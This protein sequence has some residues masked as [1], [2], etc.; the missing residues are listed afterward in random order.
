MSTPDAAA[1]AVPRVLMSV[2]AAAELLSLS[3]TRLYGL[4]KNGDI[5]SVRVGRLRRIPARAVDEF[6][7]RL[8][9]EQSVTHEAA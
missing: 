9:A 6:A 2:E 4:I 5:A 3:R 8:I 7:A 1:P